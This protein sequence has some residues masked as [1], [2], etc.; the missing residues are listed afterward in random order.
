MTVSE[1]AATCNFTFAAGQEEAD[2]AVSGGYCGDLL[3]LVMGRAGSGNA[4]LTV[5]GNVNAVAVAVLADVGC[6]IL[7]EGVCPDAEALTRAKQQGVCLLRTDLP[8]FEAAV[9]VA[10]AMKKE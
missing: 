3:S 1:L 5:M 9:A 8:A 6:M 4:W 2:R 7:C 10:A